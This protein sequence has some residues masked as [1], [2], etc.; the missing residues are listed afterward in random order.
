MKKYV[1][2]TLCSAF[3]VPGMGQILNRDLKKGGILMGSVFVLI[4]AAAVK[5]ALIVKHMVEAGKIRPDH[6]ATIL[7][8]LDGEDFSALWVLVIAFTLIWLYS[9]ADAYLR[10][11]KLEQQKGR[12]G[13]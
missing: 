4:V 1:L 11:R 13:P 6:S 9:V 10:G 2:S 5:V 7:E 3:V 8:R 12:S